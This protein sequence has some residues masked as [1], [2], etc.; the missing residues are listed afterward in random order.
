MVAAAPRNLRRLRGS[1]VCVR[2]QPPRQPGERCKHRSSFACRRMYCQ[3]PGSSGQRPTLRWDTRPWTCVRM[4]RARV[5]VRMSCKRCRSSAISHAPCTSTAAAAAR[6]RL[7][8][9]GQPGL[10]TGSHWRTLGGRQKTSTHHSCDAALDVT[11]ELVN[12]IL[13]GELLREAHPLDGLL[14]GLEKL[15][16]CVRHIAISVTWFRFAGGLCAADVRAGHRRALGPAAGGGGHTR[17]HKD[18][19][20]RAC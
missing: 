18:C 19:C 9:R 16:G 6:A 17:R 3:T 1:A 2:P 20:A 5:R 4:H 13:S 15:G 8:R 11:L 10:Q 14:D 7:R 12:L